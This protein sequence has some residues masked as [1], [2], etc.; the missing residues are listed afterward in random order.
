MR[1]AVGFFKRVPGRRR[2]RGLF[3]WHF[4][5]LGFIEKEGE[6]ITKAS[7]DWPLFHHRLKVM[8]K[9]DKKIEWL[10]LK[11]CR[12]SYK[13]I[14]MELK[15]KTLHQ[16]STARPYYT[17]MIDYKGKFPGSLKNLLLFIRLE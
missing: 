13:I 17:A 14:T 2:H 3:T 12:I 15:K 16:L 4:I 11:Y 1:H 6:C 8:K 7:F 5:F 10:L 9:K